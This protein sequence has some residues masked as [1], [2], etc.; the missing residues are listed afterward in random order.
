MNEGWE[1]DLDL[2]TS[3]G[4]TS[5]HSFLPNKRPSHSYGHPLSSEGY[6]NPHTHSMGP[7]QRSRTRNT[8]VSSIRKE[9]LEYG[10]VSGMEKALHCYKQN[11]EHL[12]LDQIPAT[13]KNTL[14]RINIRYRGPARS[15]TA[16][17]SVIWT[18]HDVPGETKLCDLFQ[19]HYNKGGPLPRND[20][21]LQQLTRYLE[22]MPGTEKY[23]WD[24]LAQERVMDLN[25]IFEENEVW[26]GCLVDEAS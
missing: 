17:P 1:R 3:S 13:L 4:Y 25:W 23:W 18:T 14:V 15:R 20:F 12:V 5:I 8:T 26:L 22:H 9:D 2:P 11:T 21:F 24:E 7:Q 16:Q 19:L 6:S 10:Q